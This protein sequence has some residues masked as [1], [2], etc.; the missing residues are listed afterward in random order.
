MV[1]KIRRQ[2][3]GRGQVRLILLIEQPDPARLQSEQF[4]DLGEYLL[5]YFMHI[6]FAVKIARDGIK[7]RQVAIST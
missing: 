5:Q 4:R 7:N 3:L 6:N 2:R 1:S